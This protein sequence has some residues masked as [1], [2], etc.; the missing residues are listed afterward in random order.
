[1]SLPQLMVVIGSIDRSARWCRSPVVRRAAC[2]RRPQHETAFECFEHPVEA[3]ADVQVELDAGVELEGDEAVE[4]AAEGAGRVD[5]IGVG[6][7]VAGQ[8]RQ[9]RLQS[10]AALASYAGSP[11]RDR[12]STGSRGAGDAGRAT[13]GDAVGWAAPAHRR[14]AGPAPPAPGGRDRSAA[15]GVRVRA[16]GAAGRWAAGASGRG[17]DACRPPGRCTSRS[18]SACTRSQLTA[19]QVRQ[20]WR[21]LSISRSRR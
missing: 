3:V 1:M 15:G 4:C 14:R 18:R 19:A 12:C 21:S 2:G 5:E 7:A 8:Q 17:A 6:Q 13:R 10:R 11:G 16:V 20:C 9:D